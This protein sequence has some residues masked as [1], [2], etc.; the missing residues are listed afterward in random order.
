MNPAEI[1][2]AWT[3]WKRANAVE[4][5]IF[6]EALMVDAARESPRIATVLARRIYYATGASEQDALAAIEA[7]M[8]STDLLPPGSRLSASG[9]GIVF[10][11]RKDSPNAS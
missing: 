11:S 4:C 8:V 10:D 7:G 2:K 1:T 5:A 3:D 6:H 9:D